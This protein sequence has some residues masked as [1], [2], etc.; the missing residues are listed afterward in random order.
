MYNVPMNTHTPIT[1]TDR[2]TILRE[3]FHLPS[4]RDGQREVI[5]SIMSGVD[6]LVLM[7]TGGGKSLTYQLP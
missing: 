3:R 1:S 7:P 2:E 5:E 6:T 4:F